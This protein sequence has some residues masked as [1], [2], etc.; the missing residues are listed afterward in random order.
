M[1]AYA[2]S[3]D[4]PYTGGP[5]GSPMVVRSSKLPG[6]TVKSETRCERYAIPTVML[7]TVMQLTAEPDHLS[8]AVF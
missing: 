8:L 1:Q 4:K 3:F 5:C 7:Y 2:M 6:V